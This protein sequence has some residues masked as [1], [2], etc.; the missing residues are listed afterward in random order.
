VNT[1]V[2]RLD[3]ALAARKPNLRYKAQ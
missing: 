1:V 2:G 3:E